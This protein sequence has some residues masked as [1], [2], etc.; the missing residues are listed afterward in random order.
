MTYNKNYNMTQTSYK[1]KRNKQVSIISVGLCWALII[2]CL[3][4]LN[5]LLNKLSSLTGISEINLRLLLNFFIVGVLLIATFYYMYFWD[6]FYVKISQD[7]LVIHKAWGVKSFALNN[8]SSVSVKKGQLGKMYDF[9][10]VE[11]SFLLN[12]PNLILANIDNPEVI[13]SLIEQQKT[14]LRK[15]QN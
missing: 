2:I 7:S 11:V 15:F 8:I 13:S 10:R 1:F 4:L 5:I 3:A 6:K 12:E 14:K 9:G